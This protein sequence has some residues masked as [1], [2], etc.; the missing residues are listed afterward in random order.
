M[1]SACNRRY[2]RDRKP[3]ERY[4]LKTYGPE[5]IAELDQLRMNIEKVTDEQLAAMPDEYRGVI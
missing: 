1:S 5:V 4:M 2:N 3:Y